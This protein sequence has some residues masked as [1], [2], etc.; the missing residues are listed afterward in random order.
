MKIANY[1][2]LLSVT[3]MI[4]CTTPVA[5]PVS[6][7]GTRGNAHPP[8]RIQSPAIP[9]APSGGLDR[10]GGPPARMITP[11][12]PIVTPNAPGAALPPASPQGS[13]AFDPS[14]NATAVQP[15]SSGAYTGFD[16]QG[17]AVIITPVRPGGNVG[18]DNLGNPWTIH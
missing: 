10:L 7:Y 4:S 15:N 13:V 18:I 2:V 16:A 8:A 3:F 12:P 6:D 1:L 5:Q 14:G 11:E 9:G 17:R